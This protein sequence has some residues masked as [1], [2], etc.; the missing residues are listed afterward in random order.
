MSDNNNT[1]NPIKNSA[2][3]IM[4]WICF[5]AGL[6]FLFIFFKPVD[7]FIKIFSQE[8][9]RWCFSWAL[10]GIGAGFINTRTHPQPEL[11]DK[12]KYESSFLSIFYHLICYY[13]LVLVVSSCLSFFTA[14][15]LS[16]TQNL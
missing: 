1:K 2:R 6:I 5:I 11:N 8:T 4:G 9:I 7:I 16:G 13:G 10:V 12:K 15:T 14:L 3:E